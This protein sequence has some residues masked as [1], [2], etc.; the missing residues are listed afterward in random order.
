MKSLSEVAP[1][2]LTSVV[3]FCMST[4]AKEVDEADV[5]EVVLPA[6]EVT[7][8]RV[9]V[10]TEVDAAEEVSVEMDDVDEVVVV[11]KQK[12]ALYILESMQSAAWSHHWHRKE[13]QRI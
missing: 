9:V 6:T 8:D 11:G 1:S 7:I 5:D 10:T 13:A 4:V 12:E 2:V 3:T